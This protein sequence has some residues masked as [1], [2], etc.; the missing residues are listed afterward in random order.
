[1]VSFNALAISEP[2]E[3]A[4]ATITADLPANKLLVR[5]R[6]YAANPTDWKRL[7]MLA[8]GSIVGSDV[9]GTVE[10]VGAEVTGFEVGDVVGCFVRG[11][12]S[13]TLGSFGELVIANPASV[14]KYPRF[15]Q[16]EYAIDTYPAAASITLGMATVAVSFAHH[17]KPEKDGWILIWGGATATGMLAIQVAKL[18]YGAQVATTALAVH[19]SRLL[20]LGADKVLDYHNDDVVSEL[21]KLPIRWVFDCVSSPK[22]LQQCYDATSGPTKIDNL[23]FLSESDI[24]VDPSRSVTITRTLAS[25]CDGVTRRWPLGVVVPLLP[26]LVADY[27]HFWNELLPPVL[28]RIRPPPLREVGGADLNAKAHAALAILHGNEARG[29]KVVFVS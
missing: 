1:M 27:T 28:A 16:G 7:P 6:A 26:E 2:G 21:K 25:T 14:I 10:E 18:V 12:E 3:F 13:T 4:P 22:T 11:G 29:E 17:L 15:G 9:A 5:A 24:K 19:H 8:V 20:E 23:L